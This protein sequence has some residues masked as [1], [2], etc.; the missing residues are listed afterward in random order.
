MVECESFLTTIF[1]NPSNLI[2]FCAL[3]VSVLSIA[4]TIIT[5]WIQRKHDRLSVKPIAH[6]HVNNLRG[7]LSIRVNNSGLGPMIIKSV[8]TFRSDDKNKLNLGWPPIPLLKIEYINLSSKPQL[9]IDLE[10]CPVYNGD[11]Q[12]LLAHIF[13]IA[14]SAQVADAKKIANAFHDLTI[15]INYTG[16]YD[17]EQ[18]ETSYRLAIFSNFCE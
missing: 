12:N 6:I 15:R 9:T 16:V 5:L 17:D 2:A 18:Y 8:E 11:S 13:D 7:E 4:L 14:D 10:E 1:S 3:F